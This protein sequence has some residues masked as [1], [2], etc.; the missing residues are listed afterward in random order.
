M[1]YYDTLFKYPTFKN[2]DVSQIKEFEEVNSDNEF[3]LIWCPLGSV[4]DVAGFFLCSVW[5]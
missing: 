4:G 2:P 3:R 5:K 1:A